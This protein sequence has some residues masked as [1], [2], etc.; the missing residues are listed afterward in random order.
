MADGADSKLAN[1]TSGSPQLKLENDE[2]AVKAKDNETTVLAT[3]LKSQ[4]YAKIQELIDNTPGAQGKAMVVGAYDIKTGKSVAAF[5]GEIPQEIDS[6]L[7]ELAKK[8]GGIGSLGVTDRNTVGVCAEFHVIN[9]LLLSESKLEDIRL[10]RAIRPRTG[11]LMPYCDNCRV[12]FSEII[13]RS[14]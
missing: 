13:G 11:Q 4:A 3:V 2:M 7:L 14:T 5:A 10:T 12:M 9:S 1:G 8:I 6:D